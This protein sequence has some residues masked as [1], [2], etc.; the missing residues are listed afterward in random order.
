MR[1]SVMD[2]NLS[3]LERAFQLA[4]SGRVSNVEE[5]RKRLKQEGYDANAV[6]VGRSLKTQLRDLIKAVHLETTDA[7]KR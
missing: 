5:I 1:F 3:A 7:V 4:R 2:P 6:F